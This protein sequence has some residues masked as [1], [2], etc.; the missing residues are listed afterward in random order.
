ML[1]HKDSWRKSAIFVL[2]KPDAHKQY[3]IY[4]NK[5]LFL[6]LSLFALTFSLASCEKEIIYSEA[7]KYKGELFFTLDDARTVTIANQ[8]S[9]TIVDECLAGDSVIVYLPVI[10]P[11]LWL[12]R[13]TYFWELIDAEGKSL[14]KEIPVPAPD[15]KPTPP[16][17]K[18]KAPATPG[19]ST[20]TFRTQYIYSYQTIN[21]EYNGRYPYSSGGYDKGP[22]VL[23]ATIE[24]K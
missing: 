12:T 7:P 17:W 22:G 13:A 5:K 20:V 21:N 3:I 14:K 11:G 23:K 24:V 10:Y 4:M 15:R 1:S 8:D 16:M 9:I 19:L 18:F 6:L 2:G